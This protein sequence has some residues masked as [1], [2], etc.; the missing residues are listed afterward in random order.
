M[1]RAVAELTQSEC[2]RVG[3]SFGTPAY[4]LFPQAMRLAVEALLDGMPN[5]IPVSLAYPIKAMPVPTFLRQ[6]RTFARYVE[7]SSAEELEM[8]LASGYPARRIIVNGPAKS[9]WLRNCVHR[10][11]VVI[12]D[13]E[14]EMMRLADR[15]IDLRWTAGMRF[16]PTMQR[17]P[18]NPR[19]VDQFGMPRSEFLRAAEAA[20]RKRLTISILHFHLG[21]WRG[22][23]ATRLSALRQLAEAAGFAGISPGIVNLGGGFPQALA[24]RDARAAARRAGRAIGRLATRVRE[25]F[26]AAREVVA[27][28][29]R[30]ILGG[31]AILL[32]RVL[33]VKAKGASRFVI[34]DG[35]RVNQAL[36]SDWEKHRVDFLT[37]GAQTQRKAATICGPTCMAWDWLW[38]VPVPADLAPND[39]LI[40]EAA[41][42][43]HLPWESAFSHRRASIVLA[44]RTT[45]GTVS[46]R[47]IRPRQSL[48]AWSSSWGW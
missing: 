13:S 25:L 33:D 9:D 6:W 22:G 26:P 8:A 2:E 44:R 47:L 27:E 3:A 45:S 40:Y 1:E 39:L 41:G 11:L 37:R 48:R 24:S 23:T 35:G 15:A 34:C 46:L 31:A 20:E 28:C 10:R 30:S 29:G 16:A 42:A 7:A 21:G 38:K 5:T 18:D 32:L 19:S 4:V 14:R 17:D 43:Y 12:F 36:P